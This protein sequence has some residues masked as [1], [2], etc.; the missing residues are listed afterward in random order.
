MFALKTLCCFADSF[1]GGDFFRDYVVMNRYLYQATMK[2]IIQKLIFLANKNNAESSY[3]IQ[4]LH[5]KKKNKKT[6][7]HTGLWCGI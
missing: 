4:T 7:K 2:F 3:H 5:S 1:S 6:T